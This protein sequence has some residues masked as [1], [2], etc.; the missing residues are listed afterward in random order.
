LNSLEN[1]N[2][3]NLNPLKTH[4]VE[5]VSISKATSIGI[6]LRRGKAMS[7]TKGHKIFQTLLNE[8]PKI[9]N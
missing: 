2:E 1:I 8:L 6:A 5:V 4:K 3:N 7:T 9:L